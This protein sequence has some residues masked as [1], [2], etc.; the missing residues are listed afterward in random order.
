MIKRY[1]QFINEA[2]LPDIEEAQSNDSKYKCSME[3]K[4]K[5]DAYF[6]TYFDSIVKDLEIKYPGQT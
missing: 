2:E 3:F 5:I 6:N 4:D 1:S